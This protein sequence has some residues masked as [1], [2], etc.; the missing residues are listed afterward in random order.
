MR[1]PGVD[2]ELRATDETAKAFKS[3]DARLK[4]IQEETKAV[5]KA[6][7][8][9]FK[10]FV[11]G[12]LLEGL[13]K[14][15]GAMFDVKNATNKIDA[16]RLQAM[17]AATSKAGEAFKGVA[18]QIGSVLAPMIQHLSEW[19]VKAVGDGEGL[20][21]FFHA[22]MVGM[23]RGVG[24][25]ADAWRG[26]EVVWAGLKIA[27]SG[28]NDFVFEGL[29]KIDR[30]IV[31][32]ANKL[33][34]VHLEYS[35]TLQG[36]AKDSRARLEEN[37]AAFDEIMSRPLPSESIMS[38][39]AQFDKETPAFKAVAEKKV[40]LKKQEA[41]QVKAVQEETYDAEAIRFEDFN[42][43]MAEQSQKAKEEEHQRRLADLG[44]FAW[45]EQAKWS[46]E[47]KSL[48]SRVSGAQT[49]LGQAANLMQSNR[50]KE[51]EVG[52]AAAI[53]NATISMFEGIGKAWGYGPIL[54]PIFA[55]LVGASGLLNI[56]NIKNQQ[57]G[58]G[59]AANV[60]ATPSLPVDVTGTPT[61]ASTVQEAPTIPLSSNA[62]APARNVTVMVQSDSG[63]VSTS[64]IRDQLIPAIN[65][66]VGDGLT[67]RTA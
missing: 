57:F 40:A 29:A 49:I 38:M 19:F 10:L 11:G 31:D 60:G 35:Q 7:S 43:Y 32:T 55:A 30:A 65:E 34:G 2:F 45:M 36:M 50:R 25:F 51:F 48:K 24:L 63:V 22:L 9:G 6:A 42:T 59:G 15:G 17:H 53:S 54:G 39:I 26:I 16:G 66:A 5:G 8:L 44:Q 47:Q 13:R 64:W 3:M 58:G 61:T 67:I 33:P 28:F 21:R 27:F 23:A 20:R 1:S 41:E 14:L 18:A 4:G 62:S 52:K 56:R 12:E 46:L 37:R